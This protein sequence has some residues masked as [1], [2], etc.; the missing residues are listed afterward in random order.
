MSIITSRKMVR[1]EFNRLIRKEKRGNKVGVGNSVSLCV[2][3]GVGDLGETR[4]MTSLCEPT[5]VGYKIGIRMY[6]E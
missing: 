6:L 1:L 3:V 2:C 4:A 5:L